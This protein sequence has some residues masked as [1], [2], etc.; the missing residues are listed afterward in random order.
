[1]LDT[2]SPAGDLKAFATSIEPAKN[3]PREKLQ[4]GILIS[5]G[6][7]NL[8]AII[9]AIAAGILDAEVSVVI[10]NKSD[11]Y[12]LERAKA[13]GIP[14]ICLNPKEFIDKTAFDSA[15]LQELQKYP[16]DW[17]VMAGYMR[18]ITS[19][20]LDAYP[21]RVL[22]LHPSLLPSFAGA[23]AIRDALAANVRITGVTV[24]IANEVFD[25]G[26][27]IAQRA[28]PVLQDDDYDS[29]A[30][31]IHVA[32]H[33]LYPEVLQLIAENRLTIKNGKVRILALEGS[34]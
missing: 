32:E 34:K 8:Q 12:G 6:G 31:R 33:K 19:T 26:P 3:V 5:G 23:Y 1:M 2:S 11:A 24:H 27:I 18:L 20:I 25:E 22:N 16:V 7:S 15:I 29:L 9:D 28:V 14:A 4:L 30:Q 13:A 21:N 17:A 10:S